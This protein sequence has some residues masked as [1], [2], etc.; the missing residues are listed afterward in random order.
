M[1]YQQDRWCDHGGKT[2]TAWN[3]RN[4]RQKPL[5]NE[6]VSEQPKSNSCEPKIGLFSIIHLYWYLQATAETIKDGW[7]HTGDKGYYDTNENLFIVGRF[8]EM[9]KYRMAHVSTL[10]SP[11]A[12]HL[13]NKSVWTGCPNQYWKADDDASS[14][15]R[16]WSGWSTSWSWRWMAIG[17]CCS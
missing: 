3:R 17:I 8:K 2:W 15:W 14:Y 4:L 16:S 9:I 11:R 7:F 1:S 6:G 13:A 10:Q 12:T 5:H